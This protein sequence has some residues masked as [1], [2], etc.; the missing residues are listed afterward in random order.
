M[1]SEF[2]FMCI[3]FCMYNILHNVILQS[4]V[5]LQGCSGFIKT[6]QQKRMDILLLGY[7]SS[8]CFYYL[9]IKNLTS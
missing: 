1:S 9:P 5:I 3:I 4:S 8:S 6:L 7:I 2:F